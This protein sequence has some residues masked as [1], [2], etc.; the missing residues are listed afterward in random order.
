MPTRNHLPKPT[1]EHI[2]TPTYLIYI[3]PT[4]QTKP[5]QLQPNQPPSFPV[6]LNPKTTKKTPSPPSSP[7]DFSPPRHIGFLLQ[8]TGHQIRVG[9]AVVF[10]L[11]LLHGR[12][13]TT[14]QGSFRSANVSLAVGQKDATLGDHRFWSIFPFTNR[15]FW[16]PIFDP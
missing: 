7:R 10:Q 13:N 1:S 2:A 4:N 3:H 6:N 16:V 9:G 8:L 5:N 15:V 12:P 11:H 14:T